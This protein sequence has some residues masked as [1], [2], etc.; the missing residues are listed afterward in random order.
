[1]IYKNYK[2]YGPYTRKDGRQHV[3]LVSNKDRKTVSYPKYIVELHLGRYLS[4]NETVD[5]I[6][7]DFTNNSLENLRVVDRV[8]HAKEDAKRHKKSFVC[9]YCR[10]SFSLKGAKLSNALSNTKRGKFGPFCSRSCA[11][12]YGKEVQQ[13]LRNKGKVEI[14]KGV[15][16]FKEKMSAFQETERV[17]PLKFRET[18]SENSDGNPEPSPTSRKGA[19]T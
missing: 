13:G 18:L 2:I 7:N 5:H 11:G 9:P 10:I 15:I 19:E 4:T 14:I 6:D 17:E 1:M 8:R 12:K 3:I 16:V